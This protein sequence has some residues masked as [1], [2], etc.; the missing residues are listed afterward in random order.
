MAREKPNSAAMASA[1]SGGAD[2]IVQRFSERTTTG[3]YF[4]A[5]GAATLGRTASMTGEA[6]NAEA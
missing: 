5:A 1:V 6:M 3:R 2:A 4:P